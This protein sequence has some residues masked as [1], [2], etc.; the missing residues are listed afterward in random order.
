MKKSIKI[1][2]LLL[3]AIHTRAHSVKSND[4]YSL[5]VGNLSVIALRDGDLDLPLN[6]FVSSHDINAT[7]ALA[8]YSSSA[9]SLEIPINVYLIDTGTQRILIDAGLAGH[10]NTP[11]GRLIS[12]LYEARY[13]PE[14]IDMVLITHAH[15][16]HIG[17]LVTQQGSCTFPNATV[18]ISRTEYSFWINPHEEENASADLK[19]AFPVVHATLKPYQDTGKLTLFDHNEHLTENIRTLSLA[20][21]TPGHAG[22]ILT[23]GDDTI[24]FWGDTVHCH[25]I[26][27]A[28]PTIASYFDI[29]QEQA[30]ASRKYI[31]KYAATTHCLVASAHI[32]FPGIG[33]VKKLGIDEYSWQSIT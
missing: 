29:D 2:A 1:V 22:F 11:T 14:D 24:I 18:Y 13:A 8:L 3:I 4:V 15:H 6:T 26:Q 25:N 16:D 19:L 33:T 31:L 28:H 10:Y 17:G 30:I 23:A 12:Q 32:P 9:H 7:N 20:G 5:P 27:C 21:H